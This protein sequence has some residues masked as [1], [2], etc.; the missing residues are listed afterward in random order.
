MDATEVNDVREALEG[1]T[2]IAVELNNDG[3][4]DILT[5]DGDV[6]TFYDCR[7]GLYCTVTKGKAYELADDTFSELGAIFSR[8]RPDPELRVGTGPDDLVREGGILTNGEVN[9]LLY[10]AGGME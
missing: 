4:L 3:H 10:A 6:V 7:E 1:K 9:A 2:V 5:S 8:H